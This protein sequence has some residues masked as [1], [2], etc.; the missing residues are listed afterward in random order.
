MTLKDDA[1][2][3]L[4][5]AAGHVFAAKGYDG[6]TVREICE[7]AEVNVAAVNYYFRDKERLYIETVKSACRQHNE[8]FPMPDW[9]PGTPPKQKLREF[10]LIFCRRMVCDDE[11]PWKRQLFLREMAQ[12]TAACAELVSETIRPTAARLG[13]ILE[14]LLPGVPEGKRL[15]IGFSIVGQCLFYRMLQPVVSELAGEREFRTYT[16]EK[17]AEHITEFSLAAL[18]AARPK[19][20]SRRK[21]TRRAS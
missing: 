20:A 13:A 6:A 9:P 3:R 15:Q 10:I 7:R 5:E 1:E 17:L 18:Q 19:R 21:T 16:A 12:P 4:L 2:R 11:A 14:E 8:R